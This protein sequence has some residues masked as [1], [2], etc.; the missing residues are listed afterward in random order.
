LPMF[1]HPDQLHAADTRTSDRK[2]RLPDRFFWLF[3]LVWSEIQL[4][5]SYHTF[6]IQFSYSYHRA[7]LQL[8]HSDHTEIQ[9]DIVIICDM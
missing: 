6:I 1:S 7:I 8:S 3:F 4:A 9:W 5:Y 2:R